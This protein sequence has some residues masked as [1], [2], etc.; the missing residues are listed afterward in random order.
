M[1]GQEVYDV[2]VAH[3]VNRLFHANSVATS[4]SLL[5]LGGLASR[6]A[7][8]RAQLPQTNQITDDIDRKFDI[9]GDA[10]ADTVDIHAR[11]SDRNNYGP[12]LFVFGVDVLRTLPVPSR[13]L[14]TRSN[15][16]KWANTTSDGE[17][18]F[19]DADELD[20][21]L[22]VGD[23]GQMLVI[24]TNDGIVPFGPYLQSIIL[25]EPRLSIGV[26]PEF[27]RAATAL[28]SAVTALGLPVQVTRRTCGGMCK[29]INSYTEKST[30]IGWFYKLS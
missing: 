19:L 2:L 9:F 18:Y 22:V 26:G 23:F 17:R 24:R 6:Q 15:P 10:F 21:G 8:E 29:C 13:V 12:V 11:R 5:R 7:V 27:Q 25:D 30:R 14:I 16:T 1:T 4:L 20:D 28:N 3:E